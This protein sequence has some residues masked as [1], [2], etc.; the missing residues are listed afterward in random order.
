MVEIWDSNPKYQKTRHQLATEMV[1][2][3]LPTRLKIIDP[4]EH[5][6]EERCAI[7]D[8]H[9]L[10]TI[11]TTFVFLT[12]LW[13]FFMSSIPK[14]P[15]ES[16]FQIGKQGLINA[17]DKGLISHKRIVHAFCMVANIAKWL[18][19]IYTVDILEC[20]YTFLLQLH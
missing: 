8:A 2:N 5:S 4:Q 11:P 12:Q 6:H 16:M 15:T 1:E 9:T 19:P 17:H 14:S 3:H 18:D 10:T 13:G 20:F 7:I